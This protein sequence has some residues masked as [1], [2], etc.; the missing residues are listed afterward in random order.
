MKML[1]ILGASG[2][3]KVAADIAELNGW[4][5][6]VFF[7][8][9]WPELKSVGVWDVV[10]DTSD[11]LSSGFTNVFVA[12][13]KGDIR[14]EKAEV[15]SRSGKNLVTLIHPSSII[16]KYSSISDGSIV[17]EGAVIKA[18][19]H[20]GKFNIINSNSTIGHDCIIKDACHISLGATIA[21]DVLLETN[22]WVGNSASIR[23]NIRIGKN[24]MIG[25]G[26]VVVKDIPSNVTVVGNPAKPISKS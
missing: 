17:C 19:S 9:A 13:G 24:V 26:S 16:S 21:G 14:K 15:V 12:I 18:F 11:L 5:K 7:D 4:N 22:S 2:H 20:I 23:Q 1:A 6:I 25:S 10:G 3:G 8:D